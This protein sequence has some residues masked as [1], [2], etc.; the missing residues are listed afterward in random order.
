[1]SF[2]QITHVLIPGHI[3]EIPKEEEELDRYFKEKPRREELA[4]DPFDYWIKKKSFFPL[5]P[6]VAFEILTTPASSASV[7]SVSLWWWGHKRKEK[8]TEW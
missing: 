4:L 1:M 3:W 7:K 5:L 6:Y 2:I 8:Q